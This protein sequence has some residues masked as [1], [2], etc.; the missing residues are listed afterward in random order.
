MRLA[1]LG[2]AW[3]PLVAAALEGC[4]ERDAWKSGHLERATDLLVTYLDEVA[5]WN[6]RTDLT[7][8][9]SAAELVD[10][11]VADAMQLAQRAEP[12]MRWVDVG[13][14]AGAPAIPLAILTG[15]DITLVEPNG[16]RVA[17][18]RSAIGRLGLK[19]ARVQRGR[20]DALESGAWD[21]AVSRATLAPPE[22][23]AE[24]TRLATEQ[25]W[26]L[27]ARAEPPTRVGWQLSDD[28]VYRWPLSGA[29]RRMLRY[30]R[31]R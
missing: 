10:L 14:G 3:R 4:T 21:V 27:V 20:S 19:G 18:L 12:D 23:L 6:K 28:V 29:E 30:I 11:T 22:W 26:V 2:N 25:V 9:R 24:G 8:A 31:E 16:K 17:F 5:M 7:A 15:V 1:P 13:S